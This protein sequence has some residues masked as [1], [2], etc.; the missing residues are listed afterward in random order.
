MNI[1]LLHRLCTPAFMV[2][3]LV[4]LAV[5]PLGAQEALPRNETLYVAGMHWGSVDTF[6]PNHP[7][8]DW[9]SQ[10]ENQ[11]LY[12]SL[13][14]FNLLT[15]DIEPLLAAGMTFVDDL[16]IEIPLRDGTRWQ[17]G[18]PL[19]AEDVVF[20]YKLA[21]DHDDLD[22]SV[23][24]DY[25]TD[26]VATDDRTIQMKLNPER[27][28]VGLVKRYLSNVH[29]LPQ[30]IWAERAASDTPLSQYVDLEPVGSG[31]YKVLDYSIERIALVRDDNYW[32]IPVFGTP[33]P[34]YV[35]HPIFG[36]NDEGNLAFQRGNVDLSQQF[37]PQIWKM[38]EEQN[39]PVGTWFAEEPYHVP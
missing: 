32:G 8:P 11:Y 36:S 27:L 20:T 35:V 12:E 34:K 14:V 22:Y 33:A 9:P 6:N 23:F 38:W 17:D 25:V 24:R 26:V 1:R 10:G 30:H 21:W 5:A 29:I 7:N 19:T 18:T 16:T 39:L 3:V 28:N 15:G 37:A 2:L 31:P 4:A 13:F